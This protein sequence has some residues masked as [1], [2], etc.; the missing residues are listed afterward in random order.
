MEK[1]HKVYIGPFVRRDGIKVTLMRTPELLVAKAE[2][3]PGYNNIAVY[4]NNEVEM[5]GGNG[6][7][8]FDK[9]ARR[10]AAAYDAAPRYTLDLNEPGIDPV[11]DIPPE[12]PLASEINK[13]RRDQRRSR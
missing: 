12:K 8:A 11:L 13:L 4:S 1:I 9:G 7:D 6:R 2:N 5:L 10:I 3:A